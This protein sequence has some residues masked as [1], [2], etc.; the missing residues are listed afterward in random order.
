M[1]LVTWLEDQI[2]WSSEHLLPAQDGTDTPFEDVGV[3]VLLVMAVHG[4]RQSFWPEQVLNQGESP[5]CVPAVDHEPV[6]HRLRVAN[7]QPFAS[8]QDPLDRHQGQL[9]PPRPLLTA[10][11]CC[12]GL[13]GPA[14]G[15]VDP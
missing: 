3:F 15:R 10:S 2:T 6:P 9:D 11:R 7:G 8:R 5:V 14:E 12:R 13:T 1:P 4:R